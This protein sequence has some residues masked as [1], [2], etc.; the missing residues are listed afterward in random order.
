MP[1]R[2]SRRV[3]SGYR[4]RREPSRPQHWECQIHIALFNFPKLVH[5]EQGSKGSSRLT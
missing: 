2:W 1:W 5:L 3:A 4:D